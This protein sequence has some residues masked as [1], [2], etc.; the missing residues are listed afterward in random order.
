M[1]LAAGWCLQEGQL[2]VSAVQPEQS[3][4]Q[5]NAT[6]WES[7]ISYTTIWF[8]ISAVLKHLS[9]KVQQMKMYRKDENKETIY[10][11]TS[12]MLHG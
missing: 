2:F 10:I 1:A 7:I 8:S 4:V 3:A 9:L 5:V 11:S 6:L 12:Y